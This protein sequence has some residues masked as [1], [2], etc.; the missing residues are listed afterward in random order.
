MSILKWVFNFHAGILV[1]SWLPTVS[2]LAW[3]ATR[4]HLFVRIDSSI[5][6]FGDPFRLWFAADDASLGF[7]GKTGILDISLGLS[8]GLYVSLTLCC[9]PFK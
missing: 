8:V 9:L 4:V 3:I 2:G 1:A 7:Y 6:T 5:W